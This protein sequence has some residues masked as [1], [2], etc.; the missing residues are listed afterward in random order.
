MAHAHGRAGAAVLAFALLSG[1]APSHAGGAHDGGRIDRTPLAVVPQPRS[2]RFEPGRYAWPFRV[3]IGTRTAADRGIAGLLRTYLAEN[4][5]AA[6]DAGAAA[7]PDVLVRAEDGYDARLG[8]EGYVLH[9]G[10]RG[11]TLR[12]NTRRGLFYGLQTL[13]QIT[14]GSRGRLVS[15]AVTIS[16]RPAYR[17]RGIHLDVARHFFPVETIERYIDVA[18]RFK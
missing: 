5:V 1:C 15:R 16:D 9:A 3:R 11:V 17:W 7:N 18:A 8:D 4:G 10:P 2:V 14:A 12:A 6:A 13:E